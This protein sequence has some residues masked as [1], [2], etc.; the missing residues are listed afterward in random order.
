MNKAPEKTEKNVGN[1]NFIP[2]YSLE[3]RVFY[4]LHKVRLNTVNI[5]CQINSSLFKIERCS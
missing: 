2:Y 5:S 4:N 1:N 3:Q